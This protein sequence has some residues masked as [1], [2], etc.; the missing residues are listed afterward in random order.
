MSYFGSISIYRHEYPECVCSLCVGA[1]RV[2]LGYGSTYK[3]AD[4]LVAF[5]H[6]TYANQLPIHLRLLTPALPSS[7][8]AQSSQT[9][10][11]NG[12]GDANA[13][14]E[15]CYQKEV[16]SF[17]WPNGE[18]CPLPPPSE[19]S[20]PMTLHSSLIYPIKSCAGIRVSMWPVTAY[21]LLFD[22]VLSVVRTP[23]H[24]P[25]PSTPSYTVLTQ[26]ACPRLALLQCRIYFNNNVDS[27]ECSDNGSNGDGQWILQL[28]CSSYR[29]GSMLEVVLHDGSSLH[30]QPTQASDIKVRVCGRCTYTSRVSTPGASSQHTDA[31]TEW[32]TE[33]I[34]EGVPADK[35]TSTYTLLR[36]TNETGK[37]GG[38]EPKDKDSGGGGVRSFANTAQYLLLSTTSVHSLI[39]VR[40]ILRCLCR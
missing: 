29:N 35:R 16:Y 7:L 18:A 34:N 19:S 4:V 26:K 10:D 6:D 21:G 11:G 38:V 12:Q 24:T 2:S 28:F 32:L 3:D 15:L 33:F 8:M 27:S 25:Q 9:A 14:E 13:I 30:T 5:L 37:E 17:P 1:C 20:L 23:L 36:T 31:L 39:Q 22:R 40:M